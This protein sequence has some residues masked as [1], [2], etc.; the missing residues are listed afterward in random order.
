[1]ALT[2][3]NL[4]AELFRITFSNCPPRMRWR[5]V[6]KLAASL[7]ITMCMISSLAFR[8]AAGHTELLT[9]QLAFGHDFRS[10]ITNAD[11]FDA[12]SGDYHLLSTQ[13]RY[14]PG[15]A[16]YITVDVVNAWGIDKA[17]PESDFSLEPEENGDRAN[18]GA[19]GR[20][21][22]ASLG[23]SPTQ[24]IIEVRSLNFPFQISETNSV[25]PLIWHA[26]NVPTGLVVA[27]DFSGDGGLTWNT[28]TNLNAY[29]EF[30]VWQPTPQFN[31][32]NA[33]W[34]VIGETNG[35]TY[36][37]TNASLGGL[38][39]GAFQI[40]SVSNAPTGLTKVHW[41]GAWNEEFQIEYSTD[42]FNWL[43]APTGGLSD[44][45]PFFI[46]PIGGDLFYE[47]VESN[48]DTDRLYRVIWN[49]F[50]TNVLSP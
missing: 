25:Q 24:E 1:M 16:L 48:V 40:L 31:S 5:W 43:N 44:Q 18:I 20:S 35:T 45:S 3:T 19:Y 42:G 8:F 6:G 26:L 32:F 28:I 27:V 12:G 38:F 36:A 21:E 30:I 41:N 50:P 22:F 29:T 23:F 7:L 34:R 39:F 46:A 47:D 49:D 14:D 4:P 17:N 10:A 9:W 2:P 11:F 33:L 15:T 37:D 13:G